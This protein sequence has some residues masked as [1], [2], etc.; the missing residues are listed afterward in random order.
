MQ[1]GILTRDFLSSIRIMK[2]SFSSWYL[3][4]DNPPYLNHQIQPL[5]PPYPLG[6]QSAV[7]SIGVSH[8]H[9]TAIGA[10]D[11]WQWHF[12]SVLKLSSERVMPVCIQ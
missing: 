9:G 2:Y 6:Y 5:H 3:H 12:E 8:I 7:N 11:L 1:M 4:R 10:D